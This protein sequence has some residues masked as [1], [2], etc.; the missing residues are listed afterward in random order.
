MHRKFE[1]L[2]PGK[3]GSHS[4]ALP[5]FFLLL[6][7]CVQC[8]RVSIPPAV[9]PT[10]LRQMDMGSLTCAQICLRAVHM[11]GLVRHKQVCT[12]VDS[13]GQKKLFLA[14]PH[15]GIEPRVFGFELKLYSHWAKSPIG[16]FGYMPTRLNRYEN[17]QLVVWHQNLFEG[18]K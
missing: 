16:L 2:P 3:A 13:E 1:L 8:F 15:Q 7:S 6:F 11:K 14:L 9:R 10:L 17:L 18:V 12:R 4:T 5:S